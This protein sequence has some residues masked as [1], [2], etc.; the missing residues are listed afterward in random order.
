MS[1]PSLLYRAY[2]ELNN[3]LSVIEKLKSTSKR[4]SNPPIFILGAPRCGSTLF[5]QSLVVEY[6]FSYLSN[7]HCRLFGAPWLIDQFTDVKHKYGQNV[8][9]ES[10]FGSINGWYSP[11]ECGEYWYRFFPRERHYVAE[12]DMREISI[13][14]LKTSLNS[15][16][17]TTNSPY[18]FKNLMNSL[19]IRPILKAVPDALFIVLFRNPIDIAHSILEAR[20]KTSN[21][22]DSW[23]S[24]KPENYSSIKTLL[25]EQQVI[26]QI[27]SIYD[28][29]KQVSLLNPDQFISIKYEHFCSSTSNVFKQIDSFLETHSINS[30]RTNLVPESFEIRKRI[31][32]DKELYKSLEK[33]LLKN[34]IV[35]DF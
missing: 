19:R 3:Q 29:I 26:E 35:Y 25:P 4:L 7:L 23:F 34:P 30:Q 33:H 14:R 8:S 32:I 13:N 24:V 2:L 22:Y 6:N 15:L 10:K 27:R 9:F 18:V 1:K 31:R 21:S 16:R 12:H 20:M 28:E 11:S 17:R 5:F